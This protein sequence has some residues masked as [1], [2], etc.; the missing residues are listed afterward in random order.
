MSQELIDYILL[1][2]F[3]NKTPVARLLKFQRETMGNKTLTAAQVQTV[4]D[5]HKAEHFSGPQQTLR[6]KEV[7]DYYGDPQVV[8]SISGDSA[9]LKAGF[10]FHISKLLIDGKSLLVWRELYNKKLVTVR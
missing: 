4:I 2:Y 5:A 3:I 6:V 10:Q 1:G 9:M 7:N 8:K